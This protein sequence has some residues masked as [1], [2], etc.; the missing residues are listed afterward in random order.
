MTIIIIS[1]NNYYYINVNPFSPQCCPFSLPITKHQSSCTIYDVI[2]FIVLVTKTAFD[3]QLM[4]W[5]EI[6]Q[7]MP[8][9]EYERYSKKQK[10]KKQTSKNIHVKMALPWKHQISLTKAHV[11]HTKLL[12]ATVQVNV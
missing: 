6:F 1:N 9:W 4:Q 8:K 11:C 3:N 10:N 7:T 2:T 12:P 5:D